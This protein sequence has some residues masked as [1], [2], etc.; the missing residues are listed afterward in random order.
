[1]DDALRARMLAC[2]GGCVNIL[3][4]WAHDHPAADLEERE[5][6]VLEQGRPL[7]A[8]LLTGMAEAAEPPAPGRC[9]RC[10]QWRPAPV[11]RQRPRAVLSRL[12]LLRL[13]R[14]LATCRACGA[15]WAPLDG[16]LGLAPRQRMTRGVQRWLALLGA[17]AAFRGAARLL[18]ALAGL[19]VGAE[20]VRRHT[21]AIGRVLEDAQQAA[22]GAVERTREA[23]E[24]LDP[25]P[26]RL[27]VEDD[28]VMVRFLDGWHEVKLGVVAGC[29]GGALRAPSYVAAR[30]S[31]ERFGPRLLAEAARR[32]ALE[33]VGWQGGLFG[34]GLAILRAVAVVGDG[35]A[36]IWKLA[37]EHFGERTEIVD[38]YHACEHI[39]ALAK[40]LYG[41][42]SA[43]GERWAARECRRLRGQGPGPVLRAL[44]AARPADPERAGALRRE[45]GYFAAHAAR[46]DYPALAAAGLPIGSG[47]V[48]SAAKHLVQQRMKRAGM[49]W[50]RPGGTALLTLRAHL[51]SNRTLPARL[52]PARSFPRAA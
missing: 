27:V 42:G 13:A 3:A 34:A 33:V 17:E 45:R 8:A 28:G 29:E 6:Q 32:G 31:A 24:T 20:T 36:W 21:E 18:E 46:M 26:G 12:G 49:R 2:A 4:Q 16:A 19:A 43:K 11:V 51:A 35:A 7:L 9:P 10:G 1:M 30:E 44:R 47:P 15:S 41:E 23:A 37:A 22:I 39:W 38:F 5:A 40:A 50:S 25:A 48:E 14:A 52:V